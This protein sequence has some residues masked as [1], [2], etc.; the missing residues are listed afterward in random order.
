MNWF[1]PISS[2][3]HANDGFL[4]LQF[5][6]DDLVRLQYRNHVGNARHGAQVLQVIF[7][8]AVPDCPDN[9]SLLASN[10]VRFVPITA[11]A[12]AYLLYLF[13]GRV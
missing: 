10:Q 8:I 4:R 1:P 13:F 3:A 5:A 2:V 11:Y 9:H 6:A 7:V 12:L